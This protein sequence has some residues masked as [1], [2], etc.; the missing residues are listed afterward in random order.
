MGGD[1]VRLMRWMWPD[2]GGVRV[3]FRL[4][5]WLRVGECIQSDDAPKEKIDAEQ[6]EKINPVQHV[7]L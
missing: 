1:G 2:V 5:K 7:D 3:L 6:A 4:L